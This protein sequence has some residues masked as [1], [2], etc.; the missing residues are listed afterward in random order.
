MAIK[1]GKAGL[2]LTGLGNSLLVSAAKDVFTERKI[3]INQLPAALPSLLPLNERAEANR[4]AGVPAT[5]K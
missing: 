4:A 1:S 2:A 5:A 3:G